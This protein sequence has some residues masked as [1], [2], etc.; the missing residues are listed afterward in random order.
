MASIE[1]KIQSLNIKQK[2]YGQFCLFETMENNSILIK[3]MC[4]FNFN[5]SKIIKTK[6]FLDVL[7]IEKP[8]CQ[9]M[10]KLS[11]IDCSSLM[12]FFIWKWKETIF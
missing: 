2:R 5:L 12:K 6:I 4:F 10:E 11:D 9:K 8:I 3:T 1:T 7:A